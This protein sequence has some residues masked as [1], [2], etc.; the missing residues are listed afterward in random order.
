MASNHLRAFSVINLQL[1]VTLQETTAFEFVS[2]G[3]EHIVIRP[4]TLQ[5]FFVLFLRYYQ[6]DFIR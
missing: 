1:G 4:T 3:F 2:A 5:T 6:F